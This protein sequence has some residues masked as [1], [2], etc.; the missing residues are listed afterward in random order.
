VSVL[1]TRLRDE[2][3]VALGV[4]AGVVNIAAGAALPIPAWAQG[5]LIGAGTALA[6]AVTRQAVKPSHRD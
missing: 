3:A 2:P 1:W 4:V 5:R 6:T